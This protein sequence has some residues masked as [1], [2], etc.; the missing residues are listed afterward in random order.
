MVSRDFLLTH[1]DTV[2]SITQRTS[3]EH[4]GYHP[5]A[6]RV[7]YDAGAHEFRVGLIQLKHHNGP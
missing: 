7:S 1:P 5:A 3:F 6:Y 4:D 2:V